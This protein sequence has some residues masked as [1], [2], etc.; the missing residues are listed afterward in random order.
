MVR[1]SFY[2]EWN[3]SIFH[4]PEVTSDCAHVVRNK[5]WILQS[6]GW[7]HVVSSAIYFIVSMLVFEFPDVFGEF[8]ATSAFSVSEGKRVVIIS[9]FKW[10]F[11]ES[12]VKRSC[13]GV[14]CNVRVLCI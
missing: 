6:Q 14:S 13:V 12:D 5:I 2:C 10:S 4:Y 11:R 9:S 8:C 3:I 7:F 1:L